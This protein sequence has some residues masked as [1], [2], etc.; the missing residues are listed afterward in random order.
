VIIGEDDSHMIIVVKDNG[1]G[2]VAAE[3]LERNNEGRGNANGTRVTLW[4]PLDYP[5]KTNL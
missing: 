5:G 2:R 4:I 3:S 1:I